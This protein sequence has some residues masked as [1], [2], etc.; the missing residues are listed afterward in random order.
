MKVFLWKKTYFFF[1]DQHFFS[2]FIINVWMHHQV[3]DHSTN[4]TFNPRPL[5][6]YV[7]WQRL[8]LRYEHLTRWVYQIYVAFLACVRGKTF[9]GL[10][11]V[12]AWVQDADVMLQK[13]FI[14]P[15]RLFSKR[16]VRRGWSTF[17]WRLIQRLSNWTFWFFLLRTR[18]HSASLG[19]Q[20]S[21]S[22]L[23]NWK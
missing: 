20:R 23:Q 13:N 12:C 8:D 15:G 17:A 1:Q 16:T 21:Y 6:F 11:Y 7:F 18:C 10:L 2:F 14:N 3:W 19:V 9:F 5:S 22:E 4:W